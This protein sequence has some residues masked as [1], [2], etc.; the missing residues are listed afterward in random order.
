MQL[1]LMYLGLGLAPLAFLVAVYFYVQLFVI[2]FQENIGWGFSSILLQFPLLLFVA[3]RWDKA[4]VT[5]LRLVG[6]P[7]ALVRVTFHT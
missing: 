1:T 7:L 6:A 2:V 3:T 5:F 4:G